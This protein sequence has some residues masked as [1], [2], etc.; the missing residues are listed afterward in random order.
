MEERIIVDVQGVGYE[1]LLP[2][3][4]RRTFEDKEIGSSVELDIYYYV[5][6]RQPRPV[7][8]GFNREHERSFFEQLI[9]VEDIGPSKA[10]KALIF[11]VSTIARAIEDG[12]ANQLKRLEGIG[13][14]T[15]QKIIATLR[16]KVS[17]WAL[18]RDEGYSTVPPLLAPNMQDEALEALVTLG[19][20]RL[21]ARR[22]IDAA[23]QRQPD[24]GST[25]GLLREIFRAKRD[26]AGETV[27]S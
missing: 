7:L 2:F 25:E 17:A 15:A 10:A 26:S 3:F 12:D 19:Y 14:R 18:L 11:S 4:V 22:E 5:S 6:E 21:E 9:Q 13:E 8:I 1:V 20:R 16:G 24:L 23:M 27:R